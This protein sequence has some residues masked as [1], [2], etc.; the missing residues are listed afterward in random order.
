MALLS[1]NR[2]EY[3]EVAAGVAKA[4]LVL[5][6]INPRLTAP[7]VDFILGHSGARLLI[8]DG[9]PGAGPQTTKALGE[10]Y[11]RWIAAADRNGPWAAVDERDPFCIAY[12]AGTT[13]DPKGVL[14]S[15]RSRCLTFS[16]TALE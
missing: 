11:E 9:L 2:L 1:G 6:P 8:T 3:P 10:E 15:H 4:G 5:V 7:E 14:I 12:T 16:A 13:G